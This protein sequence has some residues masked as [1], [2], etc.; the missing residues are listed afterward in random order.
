[1]KP[2][3]PL[4]IVNG[5]FG[6]WVVNLLGLTDA[7]WAFIV[8]GAW[9][10]YVVFKRRKNENN[11]KEILQRMEDAQEVAEANGY[12]SKCRGEIHKATSFED[13]ELSKKLN[14]FVKIEINIS[15]YKGGQML[16]SVETPHKFRDKN[17]KPQHCYNFIDLPVHGDLLEKIQDDIVSGAYF[18]NRTK[19]G[20]VLNNSEL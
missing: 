10:A 19:R 4:R 16:F 14:A 6:S 9:I 15:C 7:L 2:I 1:M 11:D 5:E 12:I 3:I 20:F 17:G 18:K 8:L 13:I